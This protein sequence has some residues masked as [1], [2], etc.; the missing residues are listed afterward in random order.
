MARGRS[1]ALFH[2]AESTHTETRIACPYDGVV[3]HASG[4]CPE[5]QGYP[6][7]TPCPFACTICRK[8]LEWSGACHACRGRE[9]VGDPECFPGDRWELYDDAGKPIGDGQHWTLVE[10]G[11]IGAVSRAQSQEITRA[12][13]GFTA[14]ELT[15]IAEVFDRFPFHP[16]GSPRA[17]ARA[18]PRHAAGAPGAIEGKEF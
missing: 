6:L 2:E 3:L 9:H 15:S 4:L 11:P 5:G 18:T 7:G 14:R 17:P 13:R 1:A 10:R 12:L 16:D 8:P